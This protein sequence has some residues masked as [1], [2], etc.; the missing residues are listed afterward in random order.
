MLNSRGPRA[1]SSTI[2]LKGPYPSCHNL[3]IHLP[4]PISTGKVDYKI[5]GVIQLQILSIDHSRRRL[6]QLEAAN[7]VL[8]FEG[9]PIQWS[10]FGRLI[11]NLSVGDDIP[12]IPQAPDAHHSEKNDGDR[13]PV[14]GEDDNEIFAC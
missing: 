11:G 2:S 4:H 14:L 6:S 1:S 3:N 10:H 7:L 12:D 8:V 9:G 5:Q 13:P